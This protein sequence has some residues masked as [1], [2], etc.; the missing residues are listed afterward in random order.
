MLIFFF[1]TSV[2]F[3]S[4]GDFYTMDIFMYLI[5]AFSWIIALSAIGF[6]LFKKSRFSKN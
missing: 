6:I 3:I 1:I 5:I 4:K 2:E